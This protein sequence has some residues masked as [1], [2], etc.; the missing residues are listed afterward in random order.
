MCA[1]RNNVV[2]QIR[3]LLVTIVAISA[4]GSFAFARE[5][6]YHEGYTTEIQAERTEVVTEMSTIELPPKSPPLQTQIFDE[7]LTKDFRERYEQKFGRTEAE[8]VYYSPNRFTYYNDLYSFKGSPE[9]EDV[10]KRAY[11]NYMV[12]KLAEYHVENYMKSDPKTKSVWEA[13]ER[14]SQANVSSGNYKM[15]ARYDLVGGKAD[16]E[17]I[18]PFVDTKATLEMSGSKVEEALLVLRR[19]IIETV[20]IEGRWKHIEG[21][22]AFITTKTFSPTLSAHITASTYT[23]HNPVS[24]RESLYLMGGS[25]VF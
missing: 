22:L 20:S 3:I 10:E 13:K 2:N 12:K 11:A 19:P 1:L 17:V 21:I 24:T 9:E 23:N 15:K 18:N 8:R 25:Y 7:K 5:Y 6:K 16:I 14:I 4:A